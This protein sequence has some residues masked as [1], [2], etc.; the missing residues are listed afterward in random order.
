MLAGCWKKNQKKSSKTSIERGKKP[1]GKEE[2]FFLIKYFCI[3]LLSL[4][5]SSQICQLNFKNTSIVF[6]D[7]QRF[8]HST[9][10]NTE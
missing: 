2:H 7:M 10:L 3:V 4:N 5:Y 1:A 9:K 8:V 6:V